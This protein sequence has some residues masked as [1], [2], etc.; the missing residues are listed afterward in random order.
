MTAFAQPTDPMD[1][2]C[3]HFHGGII[4]CL[5]EIQ[6][7]VKDPKGAFTVTVKIVRIRQSMTQIS[8]Q[9]KAISKFSGSQARVVQILHFQ[10]FDQVILETSGVLRLCL[11]M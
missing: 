2:K 10:Q 3:S 6:I 8:D 9:D 1:L 5:Y 4:I 7:F 11:V